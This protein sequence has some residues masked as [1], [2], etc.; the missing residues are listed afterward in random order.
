MGG[1]LQIS[2]REKEG[3]EAQ[4]WNGNCDI[5]RGM[6]RKKMKREQ[7]QMAR[8]MEQEEAVARKRSPALDT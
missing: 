4:R 1:R 8:I 2:R 6:S 3:A 7:M 5:R